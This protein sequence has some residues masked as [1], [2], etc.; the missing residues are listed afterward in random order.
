[1][2]QLGADRAHVRAGLLTFHSGPWWRK[3]PEKP[4]P[5]IRLANFATVHMP[6]AAT[7]EA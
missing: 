7:N 5:G 1:M 2:A 6:G 4:C 3:R